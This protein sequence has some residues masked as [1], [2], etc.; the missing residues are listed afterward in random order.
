MF[1][2]N[3]YWYKLSVNLKLNLRRKVKV[4][5]LSPLVTK[6]ALAALA[7]IGLFINI[8]NVQAATVP[9]GLN[10]GEVQVE[11]LTAQE[12]AE[13]ITAYADGIANKTVR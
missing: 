4:M 13:K 3:I 9:A 2:I 10:L 7:G 8:D 6:S 11:G 5:K 12:A 1:M